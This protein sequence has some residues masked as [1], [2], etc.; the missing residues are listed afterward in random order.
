MQEDK[1][2]VFDT[3]ATLRDS[4]A[5]ITGAIA[6]LRVHKG[7][8]RDAASDPMLLAT[9]LAEALVRAGVPFRE[10]HEVVGLVVAH[11]EKSGLDMPG[12]SLED[13]QGFHPAFN[14]SAADLLS[15]DRSLEARDLIG[16]PAR[17]RVSEALATARAEVEREAA[18]LSQDSSP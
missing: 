1:E 15:L 14:A 10:A 3:A 16:G 6:T 11:C 5:A 17:A 8:M 13:L 18:A 12:L 7:R 2:P 4:L 9:D